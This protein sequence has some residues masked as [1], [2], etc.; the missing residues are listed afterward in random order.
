MKNITLF[1]GGRGNYNLLKYI[2]EKNYKNI[3]LKIIINGLDDGASTGTL[4]K[5][6]DNKVHGISDFLKVILSISPKKEFV[7]VLSLRLPELYDEKDY[8]T[9]YKSLHDFLNTKS[10][11]S[12]L[13]L[14]LNK[15]KKNEIDIIKNSF[16][17]LNKFY[18]DK[19]STLLNYSDFKIGNILFSLFLIK[20]K[21]NFENA[22]YDFKE[23]LGVSK[24]FE[25][26]ENTKQ[27]GF[28]C[29]ILKNGVLLPNE[30]S[31][32]LTRSN[33]FIEKIFLLSKPLS[34]EKI[35]LV[36]SLEKNQKIKYLS[37]NSFYPKINKYTRNSILNSNLIIYGSGTP[38]SS[39]LPSLLTHGLRLSIMN[40]SCPKVLISNLKKESSNSVSTLKLIED[41]V[42]ALNK[43]SKIK[44][45][46]YIKLITHVIVSKK[47]I[48]NTKYIPSDISN[49]KI[50]YPKI[51]I[52]EADITT[53]NDYFKH[54]GKK[55]FKILKKLI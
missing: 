49:I 41:L 20:N 46:S 29:G 24:N 32:V 39:I 42:N 21:L 4:R 25:I 23:L 19:Y 1:S 30:S 38:Y 15:I 11:K 37:N 47:S 13:N 53:D 55:L 10:K 5:I 36:S 9:F 3:K 22:I 48:K 28:L 26:F 45:Q 12:I 50:K 17:I 8:L 31:V 14:K 44:N 34:Y 7:K 18:F 40:N 35:N 33:D 16:R 51:Q 2:T 54:D 6:F 52:I 43:F 27:I